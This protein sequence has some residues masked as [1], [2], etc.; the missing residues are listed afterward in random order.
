MRVERRLTTAV[1]SGVLQ[2]PAY[3]REMAR[4]ANECADVRGANWER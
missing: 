3:P 4:A 1:L 2:R